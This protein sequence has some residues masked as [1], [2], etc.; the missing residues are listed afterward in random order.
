MTSAMGRLASIAAVAV[1][2]GEQ[3]GSASAAPTCSRVTSQWAVVFPAECTVWFEQAE[4]T[5]GG[6]PDSCSQVIFME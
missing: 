2:V 4:L 3:A 5:Q 6:A 1:L